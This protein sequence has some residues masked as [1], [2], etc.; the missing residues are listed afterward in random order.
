MPVPYFGGQGWDTQETGLKEKMSCWIDHLR[1]LDIMARDPA[2]YY[3]GL[4]IVID[5]Q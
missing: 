2:I 5:K 1:V 3:R 4:Y